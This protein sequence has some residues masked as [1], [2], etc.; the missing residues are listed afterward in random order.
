MP[1]MVVMPVVESLVAKLLMGKFWR[2][3]GAIPDSPISSAVTT[4]V[5]PRSIL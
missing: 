4:V 1:V 2:L 3:L 5:E